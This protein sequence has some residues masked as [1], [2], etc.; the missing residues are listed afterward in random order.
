MENNLENL[1]IGVFARAVNNGDTIG[2]SAQ[3]LVAGA[4]QALRQHSPLRA[5]VKRV[6]FCE[7]RPAA[8]FQPG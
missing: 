5:D 6:N 7:V 2:L 4:G 1:T 8:G 3:G